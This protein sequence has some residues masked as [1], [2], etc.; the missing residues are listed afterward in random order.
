M[1][2]FFLLG[3]LIFG[4]FFLYNGLHH[5]Q[6]KKSMSQYAAAKNV[7]VPDAAVSVSG[8]LLV[9]GGASVLLGVKPKIG[10]LA[11]MGF[12]AGV[13]PMIHDFWKTEDGQH[14][15]IEMVQFMKN[16]ALFGAAMTL[17]G[18]KEPW[19]VSIPIGRPSRMEQVKKYVRRVAA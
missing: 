19:P 9:L 17:M 13:T 18:M 10:T 3:R 2:T 4:G 6:E 15:Q 12:L 1:K 16:V 5:F 11:I 14:R 8:A 7:P